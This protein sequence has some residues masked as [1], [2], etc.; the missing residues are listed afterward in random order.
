MQHALDSMLIPN[1]QYDETICFAAATDPAPTY[2]LS[3]C[4]YICM[5]HIRSLQ[6]LYWCIWYMDVF[7]IILRDSFD[8]ECILRNQ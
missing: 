3:A 6:G 4:W 2:A 1:V 5:F 8:R 7:E